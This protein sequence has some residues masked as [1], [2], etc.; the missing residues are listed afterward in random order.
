[1]TWIAAQKRAA[2]LH[3]IRDFFASRGVVEVETPI[4]SHASSI[5]R[6]LDVFRAEYSPLAGAPAEKR[7]G[8]Y[9]RTSPEFHMKRLLA[10]GYGDI[11]Q[12]GKVFRNAELG[13]LHNPEFTM[14]EWYRTGWDME[15][16]ITETVACITAVLGEKKIVRTSYA[17]AFIEAIG[18]DPLCAS[19]EEVTTACEAR[20]LSAPRFATL[21]DALQFAMATIVEPSLP[22]DAVVVIS[23]FPADQAVLAVIDGNDPRTARRFEVYGGSIELANG[24]EELGDARENER[25]QKE[26]NTFRQSLGREILPLDRLFL[27]ALA[28]GF[29]ACSGVALGLD[30]LVMLA[31]GQESVEAVLT[32]PWNRS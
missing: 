8:V 22:G 31:L 4:L 26:E 2:I 32:F 17:Q 28:E 5:D 7:V 1:M 19:V 21:T 3:K 6:H 20:G 14:L 15:A 9:H 13:R 12:I 23:H 30:R 25:R 10:A 29:P 27:A 18:I 16:L 11:Y 24:F